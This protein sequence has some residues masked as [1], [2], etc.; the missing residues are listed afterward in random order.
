MFI[1]VVR[2]QYNDLGARAG[3]FHQP[4]RL[5]PLHPRHDQIHQ[6]HVGGVFG[7]QVD[8]RFTRLSFAYNGDIRLSFDESA[9]A[10]THHTMVVYN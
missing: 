1:L 4:G 7:S 10:L 3:L 6:H 2:G 8:G 9:H 5:N